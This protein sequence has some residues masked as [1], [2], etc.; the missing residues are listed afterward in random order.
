MRH[1]QIRSSGHKGLESFFATGS[2]AG[3][4]PDHSRHLHLP[5]AAPGNATRADDLAAPGWRLHPPKGALAHHGSITVNGNWRLTFR[6]VG[7]DVERV[8]SRTRTPADGPT[9]PGAQT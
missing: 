5:P 8:A 7:Q 4:R 3:M 6:F 9:L 2:L 1:F